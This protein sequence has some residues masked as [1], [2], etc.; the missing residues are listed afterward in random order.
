MENVKPIRLTNTETKDTYI[1]EF[2]RESVKHSQRN[3]F[4]IDEIDT[5][6]MIAVPDLF[7]YA[8][9]AHHRNITHEKTDKILFEDLGGLQDGMLERLV[10]LYYVPFESLLNVS[11]NDDE[12]KNSK[13]TVEL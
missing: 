11:E 13:M 9:R 7:Y 2:T 1:L 4:N 8:F 5:K 6:P 12:R 3:G 10:K